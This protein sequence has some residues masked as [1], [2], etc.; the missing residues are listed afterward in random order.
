LAPEPHSWGLSFLVTGSVEGG[1][2][3]GTA[4]WAG[5]ANSYWWCD[6]EKGVAGYVWLFVGGIWMFWLT[7]VI[8]FML[9]SCFLLRVSDSVR[10]LRLEGS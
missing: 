9:A 3:E 10:F 1:R 7:F 5:L 2:G 8:G 6:R 4:E